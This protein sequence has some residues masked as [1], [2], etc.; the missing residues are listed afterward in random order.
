M[1]ASGALVFVATVVIGLG[2]TGLG[3]GERAGYLFTTHL[4]NDCDPHE[5]TPRSTRRAF[6]RVRDGQF[7]R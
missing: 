6:Q 3:A 5:S 2:V 4:G 7:V 1:S